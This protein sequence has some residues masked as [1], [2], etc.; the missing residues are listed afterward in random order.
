MII[1]RKYFEIF[2]RQMVVRQ[3][4]DDYRDNGYE[5]K[6][7]YPLGNSLRADIYA[8]KDG[9]RVIIQIIDKQTPKEQIEK[10]REKAREEGFKLAVYDIT[11]AKI[12]GELNDTVTSH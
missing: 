3:L 12:E 11:D 8:V 10:I 6:E 5:T 1:K 4:L 9:E 2:V 7:R